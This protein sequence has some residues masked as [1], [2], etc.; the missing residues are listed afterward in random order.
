MTIR[1]IVP[2]K[3]E[4]RCKKNSDGTINGQG[5]DDD[6][7][8]ADPK[9]HFTN[10][11]CDDVRRLHKELIDAYPGVPVQVGADCADCISD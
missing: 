7:P 8:L 6:K 9:F 1:P 3:V 5:Y 2:P 4:L 11:D 10:G